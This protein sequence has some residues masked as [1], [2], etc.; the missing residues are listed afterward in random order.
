MIQH[1]ME[2][3]SKINDVLIH[4]IYLV[5]AM[6]S[7]AATSRPRLSETGPKW[8]V[9]VIVVLFLVGESVAS[10]TQT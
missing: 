4:V 10:Q 1:I 6:H 8:F 9:F 5:L 7:L 3:A 2:I